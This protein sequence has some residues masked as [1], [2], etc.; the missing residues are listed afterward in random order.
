MAVTLQDQQEVRAKGFEDWTIDDLLKM[1]QDQLIGLFKTLPCPT[2]REME[3]EFRGYLLDTGKYW[4]IKKPL[5]H[6]ALNSSLNQGKWLGKGFTSI[7]ESE[8][9]GYN[10]Y[11][12][13]GK[14]RHIFP[15]KTKIGKSIMDK[16]DD[17]ELDYTAYH[18]GAGFVNMIDEV[19]KINDE[20]HLG[21]GFWG[22]F[23]RQ[24][25]IPFFFA[26]AGPRT[27]YAG[28]KS[29]RERQRRFAR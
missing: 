4:L 3:G 16:N 12:K 9:R 8:G 29:H 27:A 5:A 1:K 20:L 21:I 23:K 24:R 18:S 26:L 28:I 19:R 2:M 15:M 25:R 22:W 17:F 14:T 11:E 7:S 13:F 10:S 6:F